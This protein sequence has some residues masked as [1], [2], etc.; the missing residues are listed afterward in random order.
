[1]S[2]TDSERP[3]RASQTSTACCA[4]SSVDSASSRDRTGRVA[5]RTEEH[6]PRRPA[7]DRQLG[8]EVGVVG[9]EP[10]PGVRA[11]VREV[12]QHARVVVGR[13]RVVR[14]RGVGSVPSAARPDDD[15]AGRPVARRA[16]VR[17]R[18]APP[19]LCRPVTSTTRRP[20]VPPRPR[21]QVQRRPRSG[22]PER[23]DPRPGSV[24]RVDAAT[25]AGSSGTPAA[26]RDGRTVPASSRGDRAGGHHDD[27]RDVGVDDLGHRLD[28]R[29]AQP[30][31]HVRVAGGA[32]DEERGVRDE[33][34]DDEHAPNLRGDLPPPE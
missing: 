15:Q 9:R 6:L 26:P 13:P 27:R 12:G 21:E 17:G 2:G 32:R 22:R 34:G 18:P 25:R 10:R 16:R 5:G 4:P 24:D 31:E 7:P 28:G 20:R 29:G 3:Y 14:E 30:D 1:M 23:P 33:G 19:R 8:G 11:G